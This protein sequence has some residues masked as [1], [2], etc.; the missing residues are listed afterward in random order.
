VTTTSRWIDLDGADNVRDLGGLPTV[1]GR[2][3]QPHRLIRSDS[4]RAL[5]PADVR[6]L[7]DELE[8]RTIADLRTGV[9]V[10]LEG[11]G[12]MTREPDVDIRHLSLFPEVGENTD[13][14][15]VDDE[16]APVVL[17]WQT[18]DRSESG[19][20]RRRGAPGIYLAYLDDRADSIIDALRLIAHSAGATVVHCAAGKDRTGVVVAMALAEVGVETDAIVDDYAQ[21]AE[22]TAATI[23]RLA[24]RRTYATD[25]LADV[26]IDKHKPRALTMERMLAAIDD[27]HGGVSAWLRAHAWTEDDAAALRAKLLS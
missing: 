17:P 21:S 26:D 16:D 9:E 25:L 5:S 6:Y 15:A 14:V 3:V 2:I 1:D 22:R 11:P 23:R 13:V 20:E 18:R 27:V 8:V 10:D 4:L 24:S 12:P 19:A 7:V